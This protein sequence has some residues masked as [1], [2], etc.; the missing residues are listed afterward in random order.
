MGLENES[1]FATKMIN[2][3]RCSHRQGFDAIIQDATCINQTNSYILNSHGYKCCSYIGYFRVIR[4]NI[5]Q[6]ILHCIAKTDQKQS[7]TFSIYNDW[8]FDCSVNISFWSITMKHQSSASLAFCE[9]QPPV[10]GEEVIHPCPNIK[11]GFRVWI[12][13]PPLNNYLCNHYSG[14]MASQATSL[15]I[16]FSSV[17]SDVDQRKH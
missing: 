14:A 3:L 10:I 2:G 7:A 13:P 9:G 17:Y 5:H 1:Q 6:S 11:G 4:I 12:Y 16:V 8:R 15:T